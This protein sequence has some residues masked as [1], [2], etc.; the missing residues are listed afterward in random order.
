VDHPAP[1]PEQ[2][3]D[4]VAGEPDPRD[5]VRDL[6][7]ALGWADVALPYSPKQAWEECLERVRGLAQGRCWVCMEKERTDG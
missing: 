4:Y 6:R 5:L 7:L 2:S 1:E 3:A